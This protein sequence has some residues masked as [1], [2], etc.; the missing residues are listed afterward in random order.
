M[1]SVNGF[2]I[3]DIFDYQYH[4]SDESVL[5]E[6]I[7]GKT[8]KLTGVEIKKDIDEDLGIVFEKELIDDEK[9]CRNKCIFC[10]IDQL[11]KGM[12]ETL[13]FKYD[14]ARLSF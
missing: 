4:I 2:G 14:D 8:G 6:I 11:P 5:L 10:F 7:N 13:Y 9:V 1:L 3:K 12:R